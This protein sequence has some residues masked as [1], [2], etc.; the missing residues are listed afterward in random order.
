MPIVEQF[1]SSMTSE[2]VYFGVGL[3]GKIFRR[4]TLTEGWE[5]D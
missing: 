1:F 3:K 2:T 5:F 4:G